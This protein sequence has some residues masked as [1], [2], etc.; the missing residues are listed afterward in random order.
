MEKLNKARE[1]IIEKIKAT[2]DT[3]VLGLSGGAD[4][5]LVTLL[6][7]DA[8]GKDQV[9]TFGM[10]Y[11]KTDRDGFNQLSYRISRV[12]GVKYKDIRIDKIVDEICDGIIW[13]MGGEVGQINHGNA[14][15]RSRMS[16][17]Y[18]ISHKLESESM[19]RVRVVGTG[20]LSEDYIG[21]DTKGGDALADIFPIGDLFKSEVYKMLDSYKDAD[22]IGEWM[23]NRTPSAG[24]WEGQTD[25]GELGLGYNPMEPAIKNL[26]AGKKPE[27]DIEKKVLDL[28]LKNKHKHEAPPVV[29]LR[30]FLDE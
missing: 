20:N 29:S 16:I 19:Q 27:T 22:K 9:Y 25:E 30:D 10:P 5:L 24:L 26:L 4:S 17:L 3:A 14:R 23:I 13:A 21:Y 11:G 8:L 6:C 2:M 18:S 7:I 12:L 15:A 1:I 28:H